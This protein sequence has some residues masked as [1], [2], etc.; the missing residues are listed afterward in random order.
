MAFI[1]LRC[2][3]GRKL[4]IPGK[5]AGKTIK[6]PKCE[7]AIRVPQPN[8]AGDK[9]ETS[10]VPPPLPTPDVPPPPP[11]EHEQQ[12]NLDQAEPLPATEE[13]STPLVSWL[14]PPTQPGYEPQFHD[15]S[16]VQWFAGM[17]F[18]VALFGMGPALLRLVNYYRLEDPPGIF[19]WTYL[20]LIAGILQLA[21]AVYLY[22]LPDWST[23]WVISLVSLIV[24]TLYA[25]LLVI[26]L[27]ASDMNSVL[28]MLQ[29]HYE[30]VSVGKQAGW[31]FCML[32]V[33]GTF[34]YFA[35]RFGIRWRQRYRQQFL[36]DSS[37]SEATH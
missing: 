28:V 27:L 20:I 26:R 33:Y 19:C 23:V 10:A 25:V 24:T 12:W 11:V 29:L 15:R 1:P 5:Y 13:A 3:C 9:S 7:T 14:A 37:T 16:S 4:K 31:C 18:L 2:T 32:L 34:T 17:F 6:C 35:G 30:S 21:Y 36:V 8:P 22:Q